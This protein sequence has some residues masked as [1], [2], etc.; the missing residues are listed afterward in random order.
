MPD[1]DQFRLHP[2][3]L[4]DLLLSSDGTSLTGLHLP[5][6]PL[7][8]RG[9]AS[10]IEDTDPDQEP[11]RSVCS[12]LD[13]YFAGRR[14]RFELSLAPAGTPFQR[15]VWEALCD[16]PFGET[17][18]YREV[19]QALG[20]PQAVRAVGSANGRNP[21]AIVIP[22]HRVIAA[23]GSLGGYSGG[24]ERKAALLELEGLPPERWRTHTM[25]SQPRNPAPTIQ[26]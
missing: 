21:I 14:K 22:C 18:S 16:I 1:R 9:F 2:S 20:S 26:Q 13:E 12:Q 23:D 17:R 10:A 19:A 6:D 4:G 15:R 3:P 7:R 24:L 25:R 5:G 11:F 8:G